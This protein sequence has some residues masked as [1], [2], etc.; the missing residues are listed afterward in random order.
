MSGSEENERR[1]KGLEPNNAVKSRK[2]WLQRNEGRWWIVEKREAA[3][4]K[5][6]EEEEV[7]GS[8]VGALTPATQEFDGNQLAN[9][10]VRYSLPGSLDDADMSAIGQCKK[11]ELP[12]GES[13]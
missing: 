12:V 11:L 10:R 8:I 7:L 13:H 2:A 4:E 5:R 6:S 9:I 1:N 3:R